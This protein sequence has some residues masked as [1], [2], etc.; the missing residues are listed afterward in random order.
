[1]LVAVADGKELQTWCSSVV[2]AAAA[3]A[4]FLPC[5]ISP[6]KAPSVPVVGSRVQKSVT[7]KAADAPYIID[8]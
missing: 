5:W 4:R 2:V 1:M 7:P 8:S 3:L 6:L